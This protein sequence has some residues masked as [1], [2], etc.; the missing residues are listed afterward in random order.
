MEALM[1]LTLGIGIVLILGGCVVRTVPAGSSA[2]PP[3]PPE[4]AAREPA[5][6]PPPSSPP[7][8][9]PSSPPPASPSSSNLVT[10]DIHVHT[11]RARVIYAHDVHAKGG[12]VGR[13]VQTEGKESEGRG[14]VRTENVSADVVRAHDVHADWIEAD[15][16][17][18][19]NL[20]MR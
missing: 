18:A 14:D 3:P 11:L 12:R 10:H 1:R 15:E 2:P 16:V 9:P 17:Y 5:P 19:H 13:F 6:P 7:P 8:A 4:P 20:K